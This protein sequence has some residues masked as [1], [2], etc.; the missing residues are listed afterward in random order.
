M[1]QW[2]ILG[3]MLSFLLGF[4][5]C[6]D[7]LK[8]P[9]LIAFT[10]YIA[11]VV[12]IKY[13]PEIKEKFT[14]MYEDD[15]RVVRYGDVITV[16]SPSVNKFMNA[17][18]KA[19]NKMDKE[20]LGRITLSRSL[21]SP[22]DLPGTMDKVHFM[23]VDAKDPNDLGNTNP[24]KYGASVYLKSVLYM[25]GNYIPTY[26]APNKDNN[27]YMSTQR[28]DGDE[29]KAEQQIII[30]SAKGLQDSEI[31]YGDMIM[32]KS[33]KKNYLHV[34]RNDDL[35]LSDSASTTRQFYVYDRFGQGKNVEWARR[36]TTRQSSTNTNLFSQFAID[37][38]NLT[39]SSTTKENNPWWE[40]TLPK[41]I[42]ISSIMIANPTDTNQVQLSGFDIL[43]YDFDNI[44]VDKK[45]YGDKVEPKF[46]WNNV[47][48]IARKVR[49]QLKKE[50]QLNLSEVR[51]YGQAVN[52][53]VLLNEEMNKN[54][55][56]NAELTNGMSKSF[57][58]RILPRVNTD[59][60]IMFLL[61]LNKLPSKLSNIFIKS[62]DDKE[63]RTPNLLIQ[64]PKVNTNF[65]NLQ[66][67]VSTEN[68]NNEFGENFM[69]NYNVV[70][71]KIFHFTAVHDGGVNKSNGWMPCKF[72]NNNDY[73]NGTYV[74]NFINREFY[75]IVM[76]ESEAFKSEPII[77]LDDPE[78]YGFSFRGLFTDSMSIPRI[79]IYINGVLNDTYEIK[80]KIKPNLNPLF[81]GAFKNYPGFD[82]KISFLKYSNR[83]I[84]EK[85]IRKE[86]Q[87]LTGRL[88][89]DLLPAP[90]KVSTQTIFKLDPNYLPDINTTAPEYTIHF[91]INSQRPI[92]G[93][94]NDEAIFE[95][96]SEGLYFRSDNN[97]LFTKT[98]SGDMGIENSEYKVQVDQ[99]IHVAYVVDSKTVELYVNSK[100][101]GSKAVTMKDIKTN[102][103]AVLRVGGFSGLV[104]NFTFSN[105]KASVKDLKVILNNNPLSETFEKVKTSFM[106][107][108]CTV[109]P[110]DIMDPYTDN[111]NSSWIAFA[112]K[113][114]DAKLEQS[115][116]DFKKLADEGIDKE[117]VIKLK[118]AEKCWGVSDTKNRVELARNKKLMKNMEDNKDKIQCLPKAPFTCKKYSIDDFDIKTHKEF[119]KYIE[120]SQVREP[121]KSVERVVQLPPDPS[122]YLSK[123]FVDKNFID[124]KNLENTPAFL[125]MKNKLAAMSAS[126]KD[127]EKMKELVSKCQLNDDQLDKMKKHIGD[128]K[129]LG[130][131]SDLLKLKGEYKDLQKRAD[132]DSDKLLAMVNAKL[133]LGDAINRK[134]SLDQEVEDMI[135]GKDADLLNQNIELQKL[136]QKGR[137]TKRAPS[138]LPKKAPVPVLPAFGKTDR[139]QP[140][141]SAQKLPGSVNKRQLLDLE[142]IERMVMND[143]K[144]IEGKLNKMNQKV[145]KYQSNKKLSDAE[146]AKINNDIDV[147][148]KNA[149]L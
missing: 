52:Y 103:F 14:T 9:L 112:S 96:G 87:I 45:T 17:E 13:R 43:L 106:K 46:Y 143:L 92:T 81:I 147:I 146:A 57:K 93:T 53:S 113:N 23:I 108:G 129:G 8:N 40:I 117:D 31:Y 100:Q 121:P 39:F 89:I 34:S 4:K 124:K 65:S 111:Y 77:E 60:T 66:Y 15:S 35:I 72:L 140:F 109:D 137:C 85:Y 83:A 116:G 44:V 38:N 12:Y 33:W 7:E 2:I 120:K 91:W 99:W 75:K 135:Y 125:E 78:I 3:F 27:V 20:P 82:G 10:L 47:N 142:K 51:V 62:K 110:I 18:G 19:G 5:Y 94:G 115:I 6:K 84:P 30:E 136:S 74:C 22:E 1:N 29:S 123:E 49:I 21:I 58:H 145:D 141:S 56:D 134:F 71:N 16:W 104:S 70:A 42:L 98:N 133:S 128:M 48:Q 139:I 79:K 28:F 97:T 102:N 86:S 101:I 95:Y 68:N 26:V 130:S 144:D 118:L 127:M 90:T 11:F 80:S 73:K 131:E 63:N 64:P 50:T 149:K 54:L 119:N 107:N 61:E 122:K 105:Y 25:N 69:I 55:L 59:M 67:C 76:E 88:S 126:L 41:D 114:E 132:R 32:L 148:K 36:G 37:G 24:I 138:I